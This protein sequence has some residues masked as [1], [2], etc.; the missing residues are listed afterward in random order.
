MKRLIGLAGVALWISLQSASA[1]VTVT[2]YKFFGVDL[3]PIG[4]GSTPVDIVVRL[5]YEVNQLD[6]DPIRYAAPTRVRLR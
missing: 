3:T 5:S 2:D 1:A 6:T 4:G